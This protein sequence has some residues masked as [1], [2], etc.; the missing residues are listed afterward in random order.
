MMPLPQVMSLPN[1]R[2]VTKPDPRAR[3]SALKARL[4]A[5]T[6]VQ[7]FSTVPPAG[8]KAVCFLSAQHETPGFWGHSSAGRARDWQSRG[9]GF[10]PP[11]LHQILSAATLA[12]L[13]HFFV[14]D[15]REG[16]L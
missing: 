1:Q 3:E 7:P 13:R 6:S 9:Q 5:L 10:D 11:W 12:E 8:K 2:L 4:L 15:A 14:V 16:I